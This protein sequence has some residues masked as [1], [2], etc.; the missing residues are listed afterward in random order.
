MQTRAELRDWTPA[1]KVLRCALGEGEAAVTGTSCSESRSTQ[2]FVRS[3]VS[4]SFS[5]QSVWRETLGAVTGAGLLCGFLAPGGDAR[6][7]LGVE[8]GT[9]MDSPW[10]G[11]LRV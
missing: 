8:S 1:G 3:R 7:P 9:Q 5:A 4:D 6:S 2:T 10:V 11:C